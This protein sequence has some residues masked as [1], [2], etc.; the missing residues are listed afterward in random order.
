M[1]YYSEAGIRKEKGRKCQSFFLSPISRIEASAW[2]SIC[3]FAK[4]YVGKGKRYRE[5]K[6]NR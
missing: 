5:T 3:P 4:V 1:T 6:K 2:P